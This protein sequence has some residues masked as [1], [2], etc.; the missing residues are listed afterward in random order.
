[1]KIDMYISFKIIIHID[2]KLIIIV[3]FFSAFLVVSLLQLKQ[4]HFQFLHCTC[5]L[6]AINVFLLPLILH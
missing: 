1:M 4:D 3:L 5:I 2:L 6:N